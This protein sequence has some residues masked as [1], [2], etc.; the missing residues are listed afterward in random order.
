MNIGS[1]CE[2]AESPEVMGS[3]IRDEETSR[4]EVRLADDREKVDLFA[5]LRFKFDREKA[6][7]RFES[8]LKV[9]D[10]GIS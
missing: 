8:M 2:E 4:D 9:R 1:G 6:A 10:F 3:D 5:W 7:V